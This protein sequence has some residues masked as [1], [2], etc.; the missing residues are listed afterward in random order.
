MIKTDLEG[1]PIQYGPNI[2]RHLNLVTN[3]EK[4]KTNVD[5]E[6]IGREVSSDVIHRTHC[7][8]S[9]NYCWFGSLEFNVE[10]AKLRIMYP[11]HQ[12]WENSESKM[13]RSINVYSDK[14]LPDETVADFLEIVAHKTAL[15]V[16]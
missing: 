7:Q 14:K 11:W 9:D 13:D 5:I 1:F 16:P 4:G 2:V 8:T 15:K 3:Q 10:G 12:H 6:E